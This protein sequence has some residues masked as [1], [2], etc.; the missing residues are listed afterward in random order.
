[1][2]VLLFGKCFCNLFANKKNQCFMWLFNIQ[3]LILQI[4]LVIKI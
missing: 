1:M 4:N 3:Q 2:D